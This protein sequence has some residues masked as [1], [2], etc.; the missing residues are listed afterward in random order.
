MSAMVEDDAATVEGHIPN[1]PEGWPQKKIRDTFVGYFKSQQHTHWPSSSVVPHEDPT[2]LFANAGMNQYK[3][4]FLGTIDPATKMASLKRACNSQK[5]IRAGGKHNDLDDVGKDLYHHTFFEMLGNWSF[6]DYFKEEAI[7][8][9]WE[10]LTVEFQLDP[11]RLYVTYFGGDE[12]NAPGVPSDEETRRIWLKYV[13]AER[14]LPFDCGDNFWEM[15]DTGPCGPCTEIHYDRIG[16]RDAAHLVNLDDPDVLEIW[17]NVFIQYNRDRFGLKAL[18]SQH[19]DTGMGFE[20]LASIL[21]GKLSNYD[22]DVFTPLFEEIRKVSGMAAAYAGRIGDAD[23]DTVDMAYRVVADHV[24]T[25][26]FAIADGAVPD[27]LGRGYVL[28]RVLRRAVWYGQRFLGAPKGFVYKLVPKLCEVLGDAFPELRRARDTIM[29]VLEGEERDFNRTIDKG[30]KFFSKRA[31]ALAA[32][33]AFPGKDA[34]HLSGSLGFPLDLTEIMAEER[35]LVVD[36]AGYDAARAEERDKNAAALAKRKAAR[37]SGADMTMAAEQTAALASAGAPKT[38]QGDKYEWN[39]RP[40]RKVVALYSGRGGGPEGDGMVDAVH[41][42][43][44]PVVGVVLDGTSFYAEMGGQVYDTGA[45]AVG[46]D[47][48]L[49][50]ED[51]Q[52]YGGYVVHVGAPL[53]ALKVG[54]VVECRVDY[55]RRT[56]VAPNHTM[57]H[58][59]NFAL[60]EVLLGGRAGAEAD[61]AEAGVE[62]VAQRGSHV[63]DE[64]LRFDFSWDAPLTAAQLLAVE[65]LVN[66]NIDA[67]LAVDARETPLEDAMAVGALRAMKGEAYPDPVRV[68]AVGGSVGDIVRAPAAEKWNGLSVEL[69]GGTHLRNT[70]D[71]VG[72][73][74][75]EE[76]GIAKGVRRIVAATRERAAAAKAAAADLKE[77]LAK[78]ER[79]DPATAEDVAALAEA[80][81]ALRTD[82]DAAVAPQHAKMQARDALAALVAG[83]L[84]KAQKA[85]AKKKA[86]AAAGAFEAAAAGAG[87]KASCHRIDFGCDA[88][89]WQKLQK[90]TLAKKAPD[91][92]FLVLSADAGKFAVYASVSKAHADAGLDARA[93]CAAAADAAGGGKGG[94]KPNLANMIVLADPSKID[95]ALA[96]AKAHPKV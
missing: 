95:A 74:L 24:R 36:A 94:G 64:R 39:A 19:V 41:P 28:R 12:K 65:R 82:V 63:D 20:R 56:K 55:D 29:A 72:F 45:L 1:T 87:T 78:L 84:K 5:C 9:A 4:I 26:S 3:S 10:C 57:T 75:L 23:V 69:C 49:R 50:V 38:D 90:A 18:P 7:R 73:A 2:L 42:E 22:T 44:T 66:E 59:L 11:D 34:F 21:Q 15:G 80:I 89:L 32:G 58:V 43:T 92:S 96:A 8:M 37:S 88:K 70:R 51:V 60:R 85:D 25:L 46:E 76:S 13:P 71:A 40:S 53:R 67:G 17:N 93:W 61:A 14:V 35:G 79:S 16:G 54:D 31:D 48:V 86:D 6:G 77:R 33:E 62:R 52:I 91:A 27:A 81:K 47:P 68:V 30:A 83:P